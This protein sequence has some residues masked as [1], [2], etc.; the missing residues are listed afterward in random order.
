MLIW[1]TR[2]CC[3]LLHLP[4]NSTM[5]REERGFKWIVPLLRVILW[6]LPTQDLLHLRVKCGWPPDILHLWLGA[7]C[8]PRGASKLES[9]LA[10]LKVTHFLGC[11]GLSEGVHFWA[12][13]LE[14]ILTVKPVPVG[15]SPDAFHGFGPW[16]VSC[17]WIHCNC[18]VAP[19]HQVVCKK[20]KGSTLYVPLQ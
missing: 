11:M 15:G 16:I 3:H 12:T 4:S 14:W 5:C 8:G 1:V 13:L 20:E 17:H 6:P 2:W 7:V 19:C 10:S 9:M 18:S